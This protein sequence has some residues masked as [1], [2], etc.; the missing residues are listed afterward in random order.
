MSVPGFWDK[1]E[2]AQEV[3]RKRRRVEKRVQ[4]SG[5]LTTKSEELDVLLEL[6]KE[7]E[8]V[9]A[10]IESLV[11]QLDS[12]ITEV[13]MTMKLSGEHDD[14]DAIVAIHPGAGGTESQ[15]WAD[16]H[17]GHSKSENSTIVIFGLVAPLDGE[18]AMYG[19]YIFALDVRTSSFIDRKWPR[20]K[21]DPLGSI[22][23]SMGSLPRSVVSTSVT[24]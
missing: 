17:D 15:D 23:P 6:Q 13:E 7:G 21:T 4:A 14:R 1:Q 9:D 3:G 10:D 19:S 12:E 18:A 5:S 16:M 20:K 22:S 11:A 8:S 24:L 2:Y